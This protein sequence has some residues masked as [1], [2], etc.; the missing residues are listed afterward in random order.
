[1]PSLGSADRSAASIESNARITMT[2]AHSFADS[3]LPP[4]TSRASEHSASSVG[5][6]APP[7]AVP[8]LGSNRSPW[9]AAMLAGVPGLGSVYNGSYARGAAF[10]LAVLGTMR[11][12][13]RGDELLGF[14][15]LFLWLFNVVDAY[16][17][18]R[19][20]R[21]GVAQD[22]GTLRQRPST[23]AAE[24][25]GLGALL[26][27]LGAVSLLDVLGYDIDWIFDLW[28]VGL[29]LAGAWFIGSAVHRMRSGRGSAPSDAAFFSAPHR[30]PGSDTGP[31]S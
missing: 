24:G 2:Q 22:L 31:D 20:I 9:I 14:A 6:S 12:A 8:P 27:L 16:R 1:M 11:L 10:F 7:S 26:F 29:M 30:D 3:P 18:A 15:V 23:S 17:E 5:R 19:L 25:L 4:E 21:A 28:P 13:G